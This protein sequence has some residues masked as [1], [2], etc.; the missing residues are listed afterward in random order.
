MCYFLTVKQPFGGVNLSRS[1]TLYAG[2][3]IEIICLIKIMDREVT[4]VDLQANIRLI[5]SRQQNRVMVGNVA[6]VNDTT[7][8]LNV[9][10]R[11][12]SSDDRVGP[13][14][15]ANICPLQSSTFVECSTTE[16]III[17]NE[18]LRTECELCIYK[19]E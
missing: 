2:T 9:T 12:L 6:Q 18:G 1:G 15:I 14:F 8:A 5:P 3:S 13:Q 4:D 19:Y 16:H 7:F 17:G 11:V 10:Y